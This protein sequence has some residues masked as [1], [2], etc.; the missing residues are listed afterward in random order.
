MNRYITFFLQILFCCVFFSCKPSVHK[1]LTGGSQQ[2]WYRYKDSASGV[3]FV[4]FNADGTYATYW[5]TYR[6]FNKENH[7]DLLLTHQWE[8]INDSLIIIEGDTNKLEIKNNY[9]I[10]KKG[11]TVD[12]L[13]KAEKEMLPA[14]YR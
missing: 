14:S 13:W 4:C 1:M 3:Y 2:F 9:L 5:E 12:T 11:A 8:L 10:L 7:G 6:G